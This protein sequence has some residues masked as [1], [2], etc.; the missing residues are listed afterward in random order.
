MAFHGAGTDPD[1]IDA[2]LAVY[3]SERHGQVARIQDAARP[4]LSW[5]EHFG[6]SYRSLPPWQFAFH[7]FSRSLPASKLRQ[8]DPAFVESVHRAWS[9]AH[10][11]AADPLHTP[12]DVAGVTQPGRVVT[13]EDGVARL[14]AG[15]LPL[16]PGPGRWGAWASAPDTE[17]G[18]G[19]AQQAAGRALAAGACLVAV[20]GG[21]PLTRRL[22]CEAARLEQG[23]VTLLVEDGSEDSVFEDSVFED[24]A[25]T[26]VL[27]GRTHLV[28]RLACLRAGIVPVMALLAHRRHELAYLCEHSGARALAVPDVLRGFDHQ[29]MA[30]E[31]LAGS[32]TLAHILVAGQDVRHQD[33]TA[34]CAEG[35][36][37]APVPPDPAGVAVFLLSGGTTGLPKLIARTHNDY[38]Y[39]ARASAELCRLDERT[40]YLVSLPASHN[41]PLACPGILGTLLSGGRVVMIASPDPASAFAAI[42]RE[43]VTITAVVPAVAQRWLAH[44]PTLAQA[45]RTRICRSAAPARRRARRRIKPVLGATLQQV[46]GM[47]EGLLNYTRLDDPDEV[48][49]GTQGR[50]LSPGNEVRIVD[51]DGRDRPDGSRARC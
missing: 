32:A 11:G 41:F 18:L 40:V 33:L 43:G 42:E 28:G 48:I 6:R 7:F 23:A 15:P 49:C 36:A 19:H 3:E 24:R 34:L 45:L 9:A 4:S 10:G 26:A 35:E 13:V 5:W 50:P 2:A 22:V 20:A 16:R 39:N 44:A 25:R 31:L 30:E 37:P 21:T 8:R 27:S 29:Q 51:A 38:S 17:D 14:A 47:A 12:I 1:G 46:F